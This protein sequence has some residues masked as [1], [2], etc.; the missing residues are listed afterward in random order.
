M[1]TA[2]RCRRCCCFCP[3]ASLS[4]KDTRVC[5]TARTACRFVCFPTHCMLTQ[6]AVCDH[7]TITHAGAKAFKRVGEA[8]QEGP[9]CACI[10]R[11]RSCIF[12]GSDGRPGN[13]AKARGRSMCGGCLVCGAGPAVRRQEH[14]VW[15][16]WRRL[17][18]CCPRCQN[19]CAAAA[20]AAAAATR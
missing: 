20:A 6:C 5:T 2:C 12:R 14:T 3:N 19:A 11:L 16:G 13:G 8:G 15:G 10:Q 9:C 4:A 7:P 17:I 18:V 1:S